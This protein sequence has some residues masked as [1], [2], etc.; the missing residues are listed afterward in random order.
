MK[1]DPNNRYYEKAAEYEMAYADYKRL[2]AGLSK[3]KIMI[4]ELFKKYGNTESN[5]E[6]SIL[7]NA[8]KNYTVSEGDVDLALDRASRIAFSLHRYW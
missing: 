4:G 5:C 7:E 1:T 2:K 6:K 3:Q 8:N